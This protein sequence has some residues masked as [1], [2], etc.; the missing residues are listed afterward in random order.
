MLHIR[1]HGATK[2]VGG[3]AEIKA[4]SEIVGGKGRFAGAKGDGA[5][6]GIRP[7]Q[8]AGGVEYYQDCTVSLKK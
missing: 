4:T 2:V 5:S 6:F 3:R 1:A 7:A 8:L